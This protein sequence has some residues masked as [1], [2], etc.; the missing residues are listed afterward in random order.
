M[1][2]MSKID[3]K[4]GRGLRSCLSQARLGSAFPASPPSFATVGL[5]EDILD[6]PFGAAERAARLSE[7]LLQ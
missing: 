4:R 7:R 2:K 1:T 6:N 5:I 3:G